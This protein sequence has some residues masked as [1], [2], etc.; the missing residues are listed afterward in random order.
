METNIELNIMHA[1]EHEPKTLNE[2]RI[3]INKIRGFLNLKGIQNTD[4]FD[5]LIRKMDSNH[6]AI[7]SISNS[8]EVIVH[9]DFE[10]KTSVIRFYYIAFAVTI[11]VAVVMILC[12]ELLN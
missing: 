1:L 11:L 10:R 7:K 4:Y 12:H 8:L 3:N 2:Y 5:M 6:D 9:N